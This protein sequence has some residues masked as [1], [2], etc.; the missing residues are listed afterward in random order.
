MRKAAILF[1]RPGYVHDMIYNMG[2]TPLFENTASSFIGM[3]LLGHQ[4]GYFNILPMYMVFLAML[5]LLR[6]ENKAR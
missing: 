6:T 4:L 2:L 5:G 3:V 1:E